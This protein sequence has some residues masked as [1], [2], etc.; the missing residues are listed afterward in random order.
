[1]EPDSIAQRRDTDHSPGHRATAVV[2][3]LSPVFT[4]ILAQPAPTEKR[5]APAEPEHYGVVAESRKASVV[6][7]LTRGCE[8]SSRAPE[9]AG[10]SRVRRGAGPGQRSADV[11]ASGLGTDMQRAG[12]A[13]RCKAQADEFKAERDEARRDI[14]HLRRFFYA[15]LSGCRAERDR[16]REKAA[17]ALRDVQAIRRHERQQRRSA[18]ELTRGQIQQL[19]AVVEVLGQGR[20]QSAARATVQRQVDELKLRQQDGG[21]AQ[22]KVDSKTDENLLKRLVELSGKNL[23]LERYRCSTSSAITVAT[24]HPPCANTWTTSDVTS[25]STAAGT[26]WS[27]CWNTLLLRVGS[28]RH[29]V[30]CRTTSRS[31]NQSW[32]RKRSQS[33]SWT[34]HRGHRCV[35]CFS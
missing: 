1:M 27:A 34:K 25:A 3:A 2:T 8:G 30:G 33:Q 23:F 24:C 7:Q 26:L 29:S 18:D 13:R 9:L 16:M 11:D 20:L 17:H 32:S 28:K 22:E 6:Q 4:P 35:R 10:T 15:E 21:I 31:Q 14:R 5:G 19:E 12:L